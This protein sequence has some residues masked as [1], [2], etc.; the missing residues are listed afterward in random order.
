MNLLEYYIGDDPYTS[1][2]QIIIIILSVIILRYVYTE[3]KNIKSLKNDINKLDKECPACPAC[4]CE[5]GLTKCP[6]CVCPDK[7]SDITNNNGANFPMNGG[8][9]CPDVKCP[10]TTCP[11]VDEI[12]GSLFPGRNNGITASGK[13]YNI[14]ANEEGTLLSAYSSYSNLRNDGE[15]MRIPN[16]TELPDDSTSRMNMGPLSSGD[17][18]GSTPPLSTTKMGAMTPGE[19]VFSDSSTTNSTTNSQGPSSPPDDVEQSIALPSS[20]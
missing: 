3:N 16:S 18:T 1:L 15:D 12:V 9:K 14:N 2:L 10:E 19:G 11:S 6:D 20:T 7:N 4:N 13:Y 5:P 17:S 8:V